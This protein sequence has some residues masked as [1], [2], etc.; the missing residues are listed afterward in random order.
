VIAAFGIDATMDLDETGRLVAEVNS[1]PM[2]RL[3]FVL[4]DALHNQAALGGD[5]PATAKLIGGSILNAIHAF[6]DADNDDAL[7][8]LRAL[9]N[10]ILNAG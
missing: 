5:G 7:S 8:L 6:T 4:T 3:V 10:E 9:R 1:D 2:A